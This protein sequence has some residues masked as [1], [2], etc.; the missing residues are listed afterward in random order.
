M[1]VFA[2]PEST[3]LFL[4]LSLESVPKLHEELHSFRS[5]R[6]IEARRRKMRALMFRF[7]QSL[8]SLRQRFNHPMLRSTIHRLGSATK[9]LAPRGRLM[10]SVSR[11]GRT[12]ASAV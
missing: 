3:F 6:R 9:P 8:A 5:M 1:V 7:S 11:C 12:D 10:I 2:F 4:G